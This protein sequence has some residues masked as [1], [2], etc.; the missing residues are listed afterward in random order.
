MKKF[1]FKALCF[2]LEWTLYITFS[3]IMAISIIAIVFGDGNIGLLE[4][5]TEESA[6]TGEYLGIFIS[7]THRNIH[8]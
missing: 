6:H 5:I 3:L 4:L 7:I 2:I 8:I 1:I